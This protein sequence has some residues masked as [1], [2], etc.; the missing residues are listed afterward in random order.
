M[1]SVTKT[2]QEQVKAYFDGRQ[3]Q[4]VRIFITSGCGGSKLAMAL[5]EI[6]ETDSVFTCDGVDYIMETTLLTQ[7]QPVEVDYSG[8]G[9]KL[10]SN[11]DPGSGCS[12]CGSG[13]SCCE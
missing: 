7:A 8:T 5:D 10:N 3:V 13:G 12:S 9:F 1:I 6:K 4:P 2:A 11:L